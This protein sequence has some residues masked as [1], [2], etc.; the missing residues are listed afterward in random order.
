[1]PKH[2]T[3]VLRRWAHGDFYPLSRDERGRNA[4]DELAEQMR[5][6]PIAWWRFMHYLVLKLDEQGVQNL[7]MPLATLLH[8]GG[9]PLVDEVTVSAHSER[10]VAY[11]F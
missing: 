4:L 5:L 9:E 1:M 6:E 2:Q 10:K 8:V 7:D 3:E 11:A